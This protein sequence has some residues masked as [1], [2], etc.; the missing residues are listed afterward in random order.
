GLALVAIGSLW[1]LTAL[2]QTSASVPYTIGR[3][4]TWL[5]F[6]CV[7][8]LLLAFPDGRIARG[9]DRVVF[10]GIVGVLVVLFLGTAPLVEAFPTR[11]LW[12]TCT[13]DCPAN[14][15]FV[16]D[17]QPAVLDE[18]VRVR[19]WLVVLLCLGLCAS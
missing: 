12:P 14:A 17:R 8:Y 19:E 9:A 16:L 18:L 4:A 5:V 11:T 10:A 2:G 15:V 7:A 13:D 1:S 6:P 3:L